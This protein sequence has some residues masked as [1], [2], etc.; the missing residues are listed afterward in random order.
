MVVGV[1]RVARWNGDWRG[2]TEG[3]V[4]P[5]AGGRNV[6]RLFYVFGSLGLVRVVVV[7]ALPDCPV[8]GP[9]PND[10]TSRRGWL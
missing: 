9:P 6:L 3:D 8:P 5:G 2:P 10:V 7:A 1:R 4:L